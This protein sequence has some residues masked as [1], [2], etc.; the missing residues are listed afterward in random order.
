MHALVVSD[1]EVYAGGYAMDAS[2]VS[3]AGYWADGVWTALA[4]PAGAS[5]DAVVT[6]L[7]VR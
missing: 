5:Y 6:S 2:S 7:V 3:V 1:G 4:N